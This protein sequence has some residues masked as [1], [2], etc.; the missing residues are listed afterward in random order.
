MR[1]RIIQ[2]CLLA[3]SPGKHATECFSARNGKLQLEDELTASQAPPAKRARTSANTTT[4]AADTSFTSVASSST[5]AKAEEK[6]SAAIDKAM[7]KQTKAHLKK[8]FDQ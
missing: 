2:V 8:I 7:Q 6:K 1:L 5:A 3:I 4:T